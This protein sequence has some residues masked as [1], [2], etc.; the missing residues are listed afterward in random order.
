MRK[1]G[2][3]ALSLLLVSM[4]ALVAWSSSNH[5]RTNHSTS[6]LAA[7]A[8]AEPS[9]SAAPTHAPGPHA[10]ASSSVSHIAQPTLNP[11]NKT[12]P[13]SPGCGETITKSTRLD[14]NIIDCPND[15]LIVGASN[16]TIDLGGNTVGG[17]KTDNSAGIRNGRGYTGVTIRGGTIRGFDTGLIVAGRSGTHNTITDLE[18]TGNHNGITLSQGPFNEVN[19]VV[20]RENDEAGIK[21]ESD[22]NKILSNDITNARPGILIAGNSNT[23]SE[24]SIDGGGNGIAGKGDKNTLTENDLKGGA[25]GGIVL[26]GSNNTVKNNGVKNFGSVGIWLQQVNAETPAPSATPTPSGNSSDTA[27]QRSTDTAVQRS[28][29][30]SDPTTVRRAKDDTVRDNDVIS[31]GHDGIVVDSDSSTIDSNSSLRNTGDGIATR[32]SNPLITNNDAN[33]NTGHGIIASGGARGSG[34][35][36]NGNGEGGCSPSELC[37]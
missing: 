31:N 7:G 10:A 17:R 36:A 9:P 5:G 15:G 4:A 22:S 1:L 12:T 35:S 32:G 28:T 6:A 20:L 19:G 25:G 16:I 23:L 13:G 27:V 8:A 24:N 2:I 34:N 26:L 29:A 11:K 18:I 30:R 21:V 33:G 37:D 14:T 3:G